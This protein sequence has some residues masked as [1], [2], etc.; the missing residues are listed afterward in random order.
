MKLPTIYKM[1]NTGKV[2]QWSIYT[3]NDVKGPYYEVEHG[4]VDGKLQT[5]RTHV[6][7]GKNIGKANETSPIEQ[8][9]SEA[10][11]QWE[12]KVNRQG[13]T[14]DVPTEKPLMPMLAKTY[15]KDK[16]H[17]K[18][19][20]YCQPKLDGVRCLC[21]IKDGEVTFTSR[22]NKEFTSLHHMEQDA[23]RVNSDIT[24]DGELFSE[25]LTFQEI[26]SA[27]KRDE[28]NELTG[29]IRMIVYDCITD[30]SYHDR[31]HR[32][33]G[34]IDG[35]E[36]FDLIETVMCIDEET[37]D[38]NLG[39]YLESGY[40]GLILRNISGP[41]KINGRSN[42]LQKYKK[43][44]DQEFEL[45]DIVEGKGKFEGMGIWV[46]K[47]DDGQEFRATP[48]C[49]EEGKREYLRNR[50][51]YLGKQVTIRY[52]ELTDDGIP[53]FPVGI[54]VRDYE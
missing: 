48:K 32:I 30:E 16:K 46:C 29:K 7:E 15:P 38:T 45:I 6:L 36:F 12:K 52:F 33:G 17:I 50:K 42:D 19:P 8:C 43:F 40:E 35:L 28:P 9:E 3:G 25:E 27:V 34:I 37:I 1:T 18:F 51:N 11:S 2:Q 47:N 5:S 54:A 41:Y 49:D 10:K 24:L 4:Q 21:K 31:L 23:K 44:I 53:R 39:T 26:L 13:Y 22:R 20:C 14:E